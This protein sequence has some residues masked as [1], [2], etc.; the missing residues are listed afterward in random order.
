M[1]LET[2]GALDFT[3]IRDLR[4]M[5]VGRFVRVQGQVARA[6]SIAPLVLR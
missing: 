1:R 3:P 4:S 6:S 5:H 2:C